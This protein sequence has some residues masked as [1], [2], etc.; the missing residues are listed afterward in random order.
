[1]TN[2]EINKKN[3]ISYLQSGC[4]NIDVPL[5]FGVELEHFIVKRENKEAVSYFGKNGVEAIL[6]EL[7]PAYEK[8]VYSQE[9][10]IA[11]GRKDIEISLEPAAQLEVSI[12][13][14]QNLEE[15]FVVYQ[16]FIEEIMPILE[17]YSYE[18]HT[19]GYQPSSKVDNLEL[20]PKKRYE[21]MNRYFEKIGTYGKQMMRGTAATQVSIDYYNE[22]DFMIKY[23]IAYR[24]KDILSD[25]CENT[26]VYE[27]DV[28]NGQALRTKIWSGTDNR[29]VDIGPY[30]KDGTVS[31]QDYIDF[32]MQTPI[33]VNKVGETEFYDERT[34]G[35]ICQERVLSQQEV[36]H[37]LS[38]VFPMIRAKQ[39]LEIRFADSMPIEKVIAYVAILKGLFNDVKETAS[40]LFTEQFEAMKI[41]EQK[42]YLLEKIK[43]NLPA[44]EAKWRWE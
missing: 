31:F 13:P 30:L 22:A 2:F 39:F 34:I 36:I 19:V 10:L 37:C 24:L 38:M 18:I 33:I 28:F 5:R 16:H 4:K 1:M 25:W 3:F 42:K 21:Y 41:Q 12:S 11:L 17:K 7:K 23:K 15:I 44:Y 32:V 14:K 40:W 26:P 9:H 6:Q 29:R 35:E 8:Y 27:G 20:L 43:E